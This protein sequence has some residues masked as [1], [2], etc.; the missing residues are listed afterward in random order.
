MIKPVE[1]IPIAIGIKY[2]YRQFTDYLKNS[3]LKLC[4]PFSTGLIVI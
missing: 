3:G 2:S 1:S 4:K